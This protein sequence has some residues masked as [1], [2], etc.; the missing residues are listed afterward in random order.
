M[1]LAIPKRCDHQF[2][3]HC[4]R[5]TT[6]SE[7]LSDSDIAMC[8]AVLRGNHR[9]CEPRLPRSFFRQPT[10]Q[11][12]ACLRI[13]VSDAVCAQQ[14]KRREPMLMHCC[15]SH[16]EHQNQRFRQ[17]D[18]D[19]RVPLPA[20]SGFYHLA[21]ERRSDNFFTSPLLSGSQQRGATDESRE[22]IEVMVVS[23]CLGA[24]ASPSRWSHWI[25]LQNCTQYCTL[26]SFVVELS[27]FEGSVP[28][29]R[30]SC[31]LPLSL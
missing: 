28:R 29:L 2:E 14:R 9:E 19:L 30:Q 4:G 18:I 10:K 3:K 17:N 6:L 31:P 11:L 13:V 5:Q 1:L 7:H 22:M 24:L 20:L 15:L 16:K 27:S 26:S 23:R 25:L 12:L 8:G 21:G